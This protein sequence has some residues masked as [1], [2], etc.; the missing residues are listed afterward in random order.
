MIVKNTQHT[1]SYTYLSIVYLGMFFQVDKGKHNE[2]T[3]LR[4][5]LTPNIIK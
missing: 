4:Y 2:T 5:L 3:T 1:P